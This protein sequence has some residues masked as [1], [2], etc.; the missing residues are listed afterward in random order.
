MGVQ[1]IDLVR[2]IVIFVLIFMLVIYVIGYYLGGDSMDNVIDFMWVDVWY[3][4]DMCSLVNFVVFVKLNNG[5]V[6]NI[7]LC[8]DVGDI[9]CF[10]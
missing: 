4:Q 2:N 1:M 5:G 3:C 6:E 10:K 9:Q 8:N 7:M